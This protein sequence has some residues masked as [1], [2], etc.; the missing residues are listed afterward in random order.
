MG[1]LLVEQVRL[2]TPW[3]AAKMTQA[4]LNNCSSCGFREQREL[5]DFLVC[6]IFRCIKNGWDLLLIAA[7]STIKE[8]CGGNRTVP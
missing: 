7:A 4:T 6:G 5:R 8:Y 1:G 2:G 3:V